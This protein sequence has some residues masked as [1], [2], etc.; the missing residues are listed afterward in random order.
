MAVRRENQARERMFKALYGVPDMLDNY[1]ATADLIAYSDEKR[2]ELIRFIECHPGISRDEVYRY[3]V[4]ELQDRTSYY[5]KGVLIDAAVTAALNKIP[6]MYIDL[7]FFAQTC[8]DTDEKRR[9]L[10]RY[11]KENPDM[12]TD[13]V[14]EYISDEIQDE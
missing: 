11:L 12:E 6:D 2:E 9:K 14:L 3:V 5:S 8:A 1:V 10:I 13:D 4:E 7:I